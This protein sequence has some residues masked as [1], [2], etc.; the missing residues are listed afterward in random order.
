MSL[1]P[2]H[3][4]MDVGIGGPFRQLVQSPLHCVSLYQEVENLLSP[5]FGRSS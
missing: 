1:D 4:A 5:C 2:S 3:H